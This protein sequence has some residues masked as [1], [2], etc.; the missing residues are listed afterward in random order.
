[1]LAKPMAKSWDFD[2]VFFWHTHVY[3][4]TKVWNCLL[5]NPWELSSHITWK[6]SYALYDTKTNTVEIKILKDFLNLK[7]PKVE[8]YKKDIWL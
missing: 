5:V 8:D 2:A 4:N 1:M 3:S 6:S 7:D